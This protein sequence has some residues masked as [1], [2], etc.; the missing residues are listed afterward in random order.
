MNEE[1]GL[2]RVYNSI[3]KHLKQKTSLDQ[4]PLFILLL[5]KAIGKNYILKSE[6]TPEQKKRMK[7]YCCSTWTKKGNMSLFLKQDDRYVLNQ[8]YK[9]PE[10]LAQ[11]FGQKKEEKHDKFRMIEK[12]LDLLEETLEDNQKYRKVLNALIGPLSLVFQISKKRKLDD[13]VEVIKENE[14][15]IGENEEEEF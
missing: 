2:E 4:I 11:L 13:M 3:K 5:G 14:E 15:F 7:N 9:E 8:N 10:E 6:V 12:R 1:Q